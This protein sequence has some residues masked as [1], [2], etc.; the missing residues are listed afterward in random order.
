[1]ETYIKVKPFVDDNN[2]DKNRKNAFEKINFKDID[3]PIID[4]VRGFSDI[5]Y[6]F[7]LQC[8]FGHFLHGDNI[9]PENIIPLN[10]PD[11]NI[12]VEYRIA[13]FA[14]CMENSESGRL[15]YSDIESI[16][17]IDKEYIQFGSVEWFWKR[18]VNS[19]ILQVEPDRFKCSDRSIIDVDEGYYIEN[20]KGQMFKKLR[21]VLL[22]HHR[23]ICK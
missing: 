8:C 15:I 9:D 2:F 19:Y 17:Q 13:Y 16:E 10:I 6:C 21:E 5:S 18:Y 7:T 4:I 22:K 12:S 3:T 23:L 20:L 11:R 14:F 1:M